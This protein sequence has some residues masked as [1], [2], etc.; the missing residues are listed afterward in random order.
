MVKAGT[1]F[2]NENLK[3]REKVLETEYFKNTCHEYYLEIHIQIFSYL[4]S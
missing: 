3:I 4:F 2:Q 1:K